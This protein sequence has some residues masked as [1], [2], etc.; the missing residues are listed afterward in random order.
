MPRYRFQW[1]NIR[2]DLIVELAS[3]LMLE[4]DA[5]ES[6]K[7]RYGSRPKPEFIHDSW[8][9]LLEKWLPNDP[10]AAAQITASLKSRGLGDTEIGDNIT[11]LKTCRNTSGFRDI[12]IDAFIAMG[13]EE[14]NGIQ[15]SPENNILKQIPRLTGAKLLARVAELCEASQSEVVRASG[16]SDINND[17]T[18]IL[19][20]TNFYQALLQAQESSTEKVEPLQT[21]SE[22]IASNIDD[23]GN[24][25]WAVV[26]EE[27]IDSVDDINSL[28]GALSEKDQ[29]FMF[30]SLSPGLRFTYNIMYGL[31]DDA[32]DIIAELEQLSD[33][34]LPMALSIIPKNCDAEINVAVNIMY[35][36]LSEA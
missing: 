17:G 25:S 19:Y 3:G 30:D 21:M 33:E 20:F 34:E 2:P 23:F 1:A 24:I 27:L 28:V 14:G 35:K 6:L 7:E 29:V 32:E 8:Q 13:E 4:G 18:E 26:P 11:Y 22:W 36:D 15:A 16:Y 9:I 5:I 12:V 31:L 10:A